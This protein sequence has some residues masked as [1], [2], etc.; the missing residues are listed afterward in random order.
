MLTQVPVYQKEAFGKV[1]RTDKN[2]T[3]YVTAPCYRCGGTGL[4][5]ITT[6]WGR[7]FGVC[8]RCGGSAIDPVPDKVYT[9]EHAE[10]LRRA[11]ERRRA[12]REEERRQYELEHPEIVEERL[13]RQEERRLR[14][15][16]RRKRE[17]KWEAERKASQWIGE[18]GKKIMFRAKLV[19]YKPV[20][21]NYGQAIMFLFKSGLNTVIWYCS[22]NN[23]SLR[24]EEGE[25]LIGKE[26][27]ITA[28]VK[29]LNER[30]GSKA[31]VIS[32]AKVSLVTE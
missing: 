9:P 2:G 27:N 6:Y 22:G 18:V 31:T 12:K 23:D 19:Y 11:S 24:N 8:F 30:D 15:E 26:F 3:K 13:R 7:I 14:E 32:R 4:Y 28:T 16:A 10:K 17:A 20:G 29:K 5:A 25:F 21:T 1:I